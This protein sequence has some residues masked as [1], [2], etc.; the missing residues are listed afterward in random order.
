MKHGRRK[1]R[2]KCGNAGMSFPHFL[3]FRLVFFR[4]FFARSVTFLSFFWDRDL[5]SFQIKGQSDAKS[6][7]PPRPPAD[8]GTGRL[9]NS[10]QWFT[11][12]NGNRF[13][14]WAL[15]LS[16]SL[17]VKRARWRHYYIKSGLFVYWHCSIPTLTVRGIRPPVLHATIP[18][19]CQVLLF[20]VRE[21]T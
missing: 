11:G 19:L 12:V 9:P 18:T 20:R 16:Y 6:S 3:S 10:F 14:Y 2:W 1:T 7:L 4:I 17:C 8:S 15:T 13:R 5:S 21:C